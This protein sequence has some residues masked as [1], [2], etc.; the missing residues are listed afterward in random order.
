MMIG[1]DFIMKVRDFHDDKL[2]SYYERLRFL[3]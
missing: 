1:Q 3:W 2:R